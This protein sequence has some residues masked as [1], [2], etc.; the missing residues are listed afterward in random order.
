MCLRMV[1]VGLETRILA[2]PLRSVQYRATVW[3]RV[4]H[5]P[6]ASS[7]SPRLLQDRGPRLDVR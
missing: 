5:R 1:L 3:G 4:E 6:V 7:R 2:K